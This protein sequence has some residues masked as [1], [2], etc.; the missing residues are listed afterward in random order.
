MLRYIAFLI[1]APLWASICIEW[2]SAKDA[3]K[4]TPVIFVG[5]IDSIKLG[6]LLIDIDLELPEQIASVRVLEPFKGVETNQILSIKH[7][8][9]EDSG[10]LVSGQQ[11]LFYLMPN[12]DGS[13]N[14]PGCHRT[15]RIDNAAD[16]LAFLRRLPNSAEGNR[17]SGTVEL[18]ENSLDKGFSRIKALAGV[19]VSIRSPVAIYEILT[20]ADG[21]YEKYDLPPATY[22]VQIEPPSGMKIDF[23]SQQGK[24]FDYDSKAELHLTMDAQIGASVNF[25]LMADNRISGHVY[26]PEGK[27]LN[28]V[29]VN[30]QPIINLSKP[31]PFFDCTKPDGSFAIQ[32]MPAGQY[33]V[34][35]NEDSRLSAREPFPTI[36][37]PGVEQREKV[38]I[39]TVVF[40]EHIDQVDIHVPK[41]QKRVTLSGKLVYQDEI[42]AQED[43]TFM[44]DDGT[45]AEHTTA[46]E[47]GNFKLMILTKH[48][49]SL[50][51]ELFGFYEVTEECPQLK[52]SSIPASITSDKDL[53][54]IRLVF[55]FRSCEPRVKERRVY[56]EEER[57]VRNANAA[58]R[59]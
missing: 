9:Y 28:D 29:C 5:I 32:E 18:Y 34:V 54:Q 6:K 48:P 31:I 56:V 47:R 13:W 38:K 51:G 15:T 16:D 36:F 10:Y 27:P 21:L 44:S 49:G 23:R 55:P 40:G 58:P 52:P 2:P 19:K 17:I 11:M 8:L 30:L 7:V 22:S 20:D 42:P 4:E 35:A 45:Y 57:R 59:N 12:D 37:Y 46:D 26:D 1:T 14:I 24:G 3:W 39:V 25:V 53:N 43:I 50:K 33:R 41:V